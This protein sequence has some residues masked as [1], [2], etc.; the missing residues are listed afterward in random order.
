[1]QEIPWTAIM[2]IVGAAVIVGMVVSI[3]PAVKAAAVP[4]SRPSNGDRSG[5][6]LV[7][8]AADGDQMLRAGGLLLDL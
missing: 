5:L 6:E 2:L 8:Q 1:M 7:A 3:I 4:R